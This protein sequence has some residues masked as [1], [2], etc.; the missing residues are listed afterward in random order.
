MCEWMAV[1]FG[2]GAFGRGA[3]VGEDE[4][5][6]GLGSDTVQIGAVPRRDG[7]GEEARSGP[8]F[9]IGIKSYS[10]AICVVLASSRVLYM[11]KMPW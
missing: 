1:V 5:G 11:C 4:T 3:H 8:E 10:E 6:C 7:R 9:R 2:E